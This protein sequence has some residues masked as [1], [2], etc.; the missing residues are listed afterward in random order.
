MTEW[1]SVVG[2]PRPEAVIRRARQRGPLRAPQRLP[3]R[4]LSRGMRRAALCPRALPRP[5][6]R[7]PARR[8]SPASQWRLVLPPP[9]ETPLEQAERGR[10]RCQWS[11]KA[12]LSRPARFSE[13][14]SK[15]SLMP[16][17]LGEGLRAPL[18]SR[19][20]ASSTI[21][22]PGG[23]A[24]RGAFGGRTRGRSLPGRCR[25]CSGAGA[26]TGHSSS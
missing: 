11:P 14:R 19:M 12:R 7:P 10:A 17:A 6:S 5:S 16:P 25:R 24:A 4:L 18:V 3:F 23:Q 9:A 15:F 13:S 22:A 20:R 1:A 26:D 2:C 8:R 21:V